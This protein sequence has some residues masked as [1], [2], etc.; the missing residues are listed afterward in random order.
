MDIINDLVI[1]VDLGA[2]NIRAGLVENAR[3]K[4]FAE[5]RVPIN[6]VNPYD[7]VDAIKKT[8][9]EVKV[10]GVKG[11]G[12][13]IPSLVDRKQG[14]V[15]YVQN[16]P[17]WKMVYLK[18][19]LEDHFKIPVY[20]DNDCNC[21]AIGER[22][23]GHGQK[24]ENFVGL[25]IGTGMGAGI[26]NRGKLIADSNCGSGEFGSIPYLNRIYEDYC[27][28]KF[29]N[30]FYKESAEKIAEKA[31]I[32]DPTSIKAYNEF[33]RHLGNAIKTMMFTVDP[34]MV[35]IGGSIAKS[36]NLFEAEMLEEVK[37]F[38]YPNSLVKF[39]ILFSSLENP[40]ILGAAA[41]FLDATKNN[42]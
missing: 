21:F 25:T 5:N 34:E 35:I 38:P 11:I 14:I 16:I 12:I 4:K 6:A 20:L 36:R 8:I 26:V 29:F 39:K 18:R 17:S 10:N 42:K 7:V 23:Y 9:A 41:M 33:G 37:K 28:G 30:I 32:K 13:G 24:F 2:T 19:M 1:G 22:L 40:A 3:V 31:T 27:S 15:Y